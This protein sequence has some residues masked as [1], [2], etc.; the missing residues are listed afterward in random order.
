MISQ[1]PNHHELVCVLMPKEL[2]RVWHMGHL[3]KKIGVKYLVLCLDCF[4]SWRILLGNLR[5][6]REQKRTAV[7][8]LTVTGLNYLLGLPTV[9]M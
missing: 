5:E 2:I 4:R 9:P 8:T 3:N 6:S 1:K 7:A